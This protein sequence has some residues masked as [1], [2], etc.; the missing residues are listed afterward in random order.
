MIILSAFT[1]P[2]VIPNPK[3]FGNNSL[4]TV[5]HGFHVNEVWLKTLKTHFVKIT[6][7]TH[8]L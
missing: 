3:L 1:Y 4:A 6:H 7:L 2:H 5:F 8:V